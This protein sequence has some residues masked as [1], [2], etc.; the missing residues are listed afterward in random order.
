MMDV[1][2]INKRMNIII[3]EFD[4]YEKYLPGSRLSLHNLYEF[5]ADAEAAAFKK[6]GTGWR[7]CYSLANTVMCYERYD[8][9]LEQWFFVKNLKYDAND[10]ESKALA[11]LEGLYQ[12]ALKMQKKG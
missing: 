5:V 8:K 2:D 3:P 1:D 11:Q 12:C 7:P 6:D 10:A 9:D 4:L